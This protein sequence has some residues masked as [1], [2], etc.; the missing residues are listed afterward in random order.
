M[1]QSGES[2]AW[3]TSSGNDDGSGVTAQLTDAARSL[4]GQAK[5][6][7]ASLT[8]DAKEQAGAFVDRQVGFGAEL[9]TNVAGSMRAAA[10]SLDESVPQLADLTRKAAGSIEDFADSIRDQSAGELFQTAQDIA[11]RRPAI[12]F[13]AA[14]FLGFMAYR[15]L[16]PGESGAST[17]SATPRQDNSGFQPRES[18]RGN[19]G[20]L[21]EAGKSYGPVRGAGQSYGG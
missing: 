1:V 4:A 15:L 14:T 19:S 6:T 21:G 3:A 5:Q 9:A 8:E 10:D 18:A 2:G 16:S 20:T 7:A 17:S 13:G 12:V 11:R